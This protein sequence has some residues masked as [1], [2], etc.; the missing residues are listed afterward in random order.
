MRFEAG[1]VFA[2]YTVVSRLGRGGMATV[3]LVREPGI[4]R[5][6]ALKVLPEKLLDDDSQF[7][8]RFEQEARVVGGLDHPNIIP[9]Y[10]YGITDDVPWMALRYVD[11]G[12]LAGRFAAGPLSVPD[13]LAILR[14][15][16][17]ALD[18]AHRKGV[19][20]RDL[21]PQNILLTSEGAAY[22]ADFGIAKLL[23][24]GKLQT[25]AG[26]VLG[27]PAYMAPEQAQGLAL[28]PYTDVYALAVMCFRW[29]TG[30]LPFDS[31]TP[32]AILFAHVTDPVPVD[33]LHGLPPAVTEVLVRGLA[34]LP[35]HRFQSAGVLIAALTDA[36]SA[37][38]TPAWVA[39][40][41]VNPT[42]VTPSRSVSVLEAHSE[43]TTL[44]P[45]VAATIGTPAMPAASP[46]VAI[47]PRTTSATPVGVPA[48]HR[49]GR[50]Q[51]IGVPVL[52]LAVVT[53]S[54]VWWRSTDQA[55]SPT[56]AGIEPQAA[57]PAIHAKSVA[58]LPFANLSSDKE[59][60][61]FAGG[62]Q[63]EILTR[64]AKISAL[65]V[66]SRSATRKYVDVIEDLP[67]IARKL[68]VAHIVEGGVQRVG[69]SVRINVELTQA[70]NE[71]ILW[72]ESYDR[73]VDDLFGIQSEVATAI[74]AALN[75]TL[76]GDE[77]RAVVERPTSVAPAYDAYLKGLTHEAFGSQ[78]RA[79][80]ILA[81]DHFREAVRLDP[82]F[83]EAWMHK[84][85][86]GSLL[87]FYFVDRTPASLSGI[88]RAVDTVARL[89]PDSGEAWLALGYYQFLALRDFQAGKRAF[90]QALQRMPNSPDVL[91]QLALLERRIDNMPGAIAQMQRAAEIDPHNPAWST[92]LGEFLL[93]SRRFAEARAAYD[94]ALNV[95]H[96]DAAPAAGKAAAWQAEGDLDAAQ[97]VLAAIPADAQSNKA[98]LIVELEQF[99]LLRRYDR[100]LA[101]CAEL[102][103]LETLTTSAAAALDHGLGDLPIYARIADAQRLQGNAA[104]A[105]ATYRQMLTIT[106]EASTPADEFA[107]AG[108]AAA[109]HAGLGDQAAALRE[110]QRAV[111]LNQGDTREGPIAV[112]QLAMVHAHFGDADAAIALL[113][114]SLEVPY[115]TTV[116]LLRLQPVWDPIRND[117][118][119]QKLSGER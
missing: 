112:Q 25:A 85:F 103:C 81:R 116:A 76:T 60:G 42:P 74:A 7:A 38:S 2:G 31:D 114:D 48:G 100:L 80:S 79:E 29:L 36:L 67:E 90:E 1:T 70:S 73:K 49:S 20:H 62:V 52:A 53:G 37:V 16:A 35:E 15:V 93:A 44:A 59:N 19:I 105:T 56:A 51:R 9:L 78:A 96:R 115:G 84:V 75:A 82:D 89:R 92:F 102:L 101:R 119:F 106:R 104:A 47:Q 34:K 21:K 72:S 113:T 46:P 87:Y 83:A 66:S 65:K 5:L 26:A 86:T 91:A 4:D 17:S 117:P 69:D 55:A 22:L 111:T 12:D 107:F 6:V 40:T 54:V 57:I 23:E 77:Q 10:R 18:Y 27:T 63:Q 64:L 43:P 99:L 97:A 45:R 71:E 28:G 50:W 30:N 8:G 14:A 110:A 13:G 68:R 61:Y 108:F 41:M 118:R 58:I 94:L 3:Y 88:K 98:A 11:G 39:A 33:A 95:T 32:H 109:A 24:S